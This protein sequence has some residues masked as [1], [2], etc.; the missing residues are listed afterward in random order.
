MNLEVIYIDSDIIVVNKPAG[1]AVHATQ[2]VESSDKFLTDLL[3]EKFPEIGAVGDEPKLRPGLV[4]R[5]DKDTSGIMVVA[6]TQASFEILKNIFKNR[7]AEKTYL[8]IVCGKMREQ[9]GTVSLP[10]GRMVGNPLKRGVERGRSRIRG[11]RDAVTEFK[12][13]KSGENYS[14]VELKPQTGRMHQIRVHLKSLGYPVA[15]DKKYGGEK[16]CC[17]E[18]ISR[19]LLHAKSLSFSLPD[20][21]RFH[22]EVEA[23]EDFRKAAEAIDSIV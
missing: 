6:R 16:V 19:Q 4:H 21:K 13:L 9:K 3:L 7:L 17:P 12:V 20:G 8:A 18:G 15:C 14:L 11:A 23:P 1:T 5:L 10:I 2:G 22:F